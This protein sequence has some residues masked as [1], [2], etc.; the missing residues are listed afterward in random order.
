M[1]DEGEEPPVSD[2][3]TPALS[4]VSS[5]VS[6]GVDDD[7]ESVDRKRELSISPSNKGKTVRKLPRTAYGWVRS[8]GTEVA[9]QHNSDDCDSHRTHANVDDAAITVTR[10]GLGLVRNHATITREAGL[11]TSKSA[12]ASRK[13]REKVASG[14]YIVREKSLETWK[15]K[16]SNLDPGA[17]F[18]RTNSRK[19]LHS[20]CSTWL[21]MKEPGDTTRFKQHVKTCRAKPIS[22]GGTLMG[23]G[24]LKPKSGGKDRAVEGGR[25]EATMPCRGVSDMDGLHVDRYLK[26]TGAGGGGGR[27]I[28]VISRERFK[29]KFRYLTCPQKEVVQATQRAEWVW[30]NDHSNLRVHATDCER[31]TSNR[32]LDSSLCTKCKRLLTLKAF[33]NLTRKKTPLA[34]NLKYTNLQYLSPTLAHIYAKAKGLRAIIEQPVSNA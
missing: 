13:L 31:F 23:M 4:N 24:W 5:T 27:S 32:S 2:I 7:V 14:T 33:I 11:G 6:N 1:T 12:L 18:D 3:D 15:E 34:E 25:G 29:K 8:S 16:I 19:V 21:L 20:S 9:Y 22:T 10:T 17:R 28:H 30:R 26:R